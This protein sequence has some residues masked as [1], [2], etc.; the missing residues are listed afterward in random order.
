MTVDLVAA[1]VEWTSGLRLALLSSFASSLPPLARDQAAVALGPL[2]RSDLFRRAV[3]DRLARAAT[4][5]GRASLHVRGLLAAAVLVDP[6]RVTDDALAEA[7]ALLDI[8]DA[9]GA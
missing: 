1:Q 3:R 4:E 9:A 2:R 6:D 5:E 8:E 7:R